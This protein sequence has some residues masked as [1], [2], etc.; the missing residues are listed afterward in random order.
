[1]QTIFVGRQGIY[2]RNLRLYAYELLYRDNLENRAVLNNG[3]QAS[4]RVILNAFLEFG[5]ERIASDRRVFL[6]LTRNLLVEQQPI[7]FEKERVVLEILEDVEIDEQLIESVASLAKKGYT[8]A[9][10][11]FAFEPRWKP[12]L[13]FVKIIKI[14]VPALEWNGLAARVRKLKDFNLLLL[15]EKVE[16]RDEYK[17]LRDLHFD[18]FQ[19]YFFS[20]PQIIS[21]NRLSGNQL[22][23]LRLLASLNDPSVTPEQLETLIGQDP[24]LVFKILRFLNSAA[25]ALPRKVE[26]IKQAIIY[27]G[28]RRLQAWASL[29]VLSRIEDKPEEL[30]TIALVRAHMCASLMTQIDT[31]W[32]EQAFT[33]G[34]LSILD[35]LMDRPLAEIIPQVPLS[36]SIKAALLDRT[37]VLGETLTCSLAFENCDW[38]NTRCQN[39]PQDMLQEIYNNSSDLAFRERREL[40]RAC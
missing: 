29:I 16:T 40:L 21:G 28:T 26:S 12:L 4:S 10:D 14:D 25:V 15:A 7:P 22:V 2:D 32:V 31:E 24:S 9:L 20:R 23:I 13:P 35:S 39:I 17:Q 3:D 27:I 11:D 19:G 8:F 30:F 34:L 36:D 6:N 37:G 5:L 33:T 18:L 38:D 1:M